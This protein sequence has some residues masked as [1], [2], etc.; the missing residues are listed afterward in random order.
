MVY[1]AASCSIQGLEKDWTGKGRSLFVSK[2][3]DLMDG[4]MDRK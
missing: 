2:M 1:F 4:W 3:K